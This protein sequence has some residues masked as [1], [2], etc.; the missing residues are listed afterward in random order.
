ME[1]SQTSPSSKKILKK[2][3]AVI[4]PNRSAEGVEEYKIS[5]LALTISH[6]KKII[7]PSRITTLE[8]FKKYE[9]DLK[10]EPWYIFVEKTYIYGYAPFGNACI[11][12]NKPEEVWSRLNT[13]QGFEKLT[14]RYGVNTTNRKTFV[15]GT[16]II[17]TDF[18]TEPIPDSSMPR[19]Y[20]IPQKRAPIMAKIYKEEL[21]NFTPEEVSKYMPVSGIMNPMKMRLEIVPSTYKLS[22][23]STDNIEKSIKE[24]PN[25]TFNA[26]SDRYSGIFVS[27]LSDNRGNSFTFPSLFNLADGKHIMEIYQRLE[28]PIPGIDVNSTNGNELYQVVITYIE[29][30]FKYNNSNNLPQILDIS[31]IKNTYYV[32]DKLTQ[33]PKQVNYFM[34]TRMNTMNVYILANLVF[35]FLLFK[36]T[37]P[38]TPYKKNKDELKSWIEELKTKNSKIINISTA[39]ELVNPEQMNEKVIQDVAPYINANSLHRTKTQIETEE[40]GPDLI[41]FA[42]LDNY[43]AQFED[44]VEEEYEPLRESLKQPISDEFASPLKREIGGSDPEGKSNKEQSI[45]HNREKYLKYK[46]KYLTLK[47][48]LGL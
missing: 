32:P 13:K 28:K 31:I 26:E 19:K 12:A 41:P 11:F 42:E 33:K 27:I 10:K 3:E 47:A 9:S 21:S 5:I 20:N 38:T 37:N 22:G 34:I 45:K 40:G 7:L 43:I 39:C 30:L 24:D 29:E 17:N 36:K 35:D 14:K 48:K 8:E 6:G 15:K 44:K 25:L 4:E 2:L 16:N 46:A 18:M 1:D 23:K